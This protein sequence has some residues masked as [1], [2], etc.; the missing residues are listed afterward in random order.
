MINTHDPETVHLNLTSTVDILNACTNLATICSEFPTEI[1]V[2][3]IYNYIKCSSNP[4]DDEV[5]FFVDLHNGSLNTKDHRGGISPEF[6]YKKANIKFINDQLPDN[7]SVVVDDD[8][9]IT[10]HED[11][12]EPLV[13]VYTTKKTGEIVTSQA[14]FTPLPSIDLDNDKFRDTV[15]LDTLHDT[16]FIVYWLDKFKKSHE[17][18]QREVKK[19][20]GSKNVYYTDFSESIGILS[21]TEFTKDNS[22]GLIFDVD[23]NDSDFGGTVPYP[24]TGAVY[25]L[26][27]DDTR[28]L[29]EDMSQMTTSVFRRNIAHLGEYYKDRDDAKPTTASFSTRP[30]GVN[31]VS[32]IKHYMRIHSLK[33]DF[34]TILSDTLKGMYNVLFFMKNSEQLAKIGKPQIQRKIENAIYKVDWLCNK[35]NIPRQ[36]QPAS[37]TDSNSVLG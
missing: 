26:V 22:T 9:N 31:L 14:K 4:M 7:Q 28:S 29:M 17:Y 36:G 32:D 30:H 10:V 2:G 12:V 3:N 23:G 16:R 15:G 25:Y 33:S 11:P 18:V 34:E 21:L 13:D 27:D 1:S 37:K 20:L 24:Y 5:A 19:V 8:L 35:L 6:D